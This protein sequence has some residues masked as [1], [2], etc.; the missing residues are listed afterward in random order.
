MLDTVMLRLRMADG[1]DLA[2]FATEFGD[3]AAHIVASAL[4]A[5]SHEG[6]VLLDRM[7]AQLAGPDASWGVHGHVQSAAAAGP[8]QGVG[9]QK[10]HGVQRG[11]VR[12]AR[13]AD[14]GG[15]LLSNDIISDVF[16]ALSELPGKRT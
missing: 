10:V 13:L 1:L 9:A 6:L 5:R 12:H 15:F 14:P 11:T 16:A 7:P 8:S 3:R 2:Q 4:A